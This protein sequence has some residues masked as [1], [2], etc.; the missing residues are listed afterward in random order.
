MILVSNFTTKQRINR[1]HV[2]GWERMVMLQHQSKKLLNIVQEEMSRV[3]VLQ[4]VVFVLVRT[5]VALH[6]NIMGKRRI[7][8]GSI[9]TSPK[10]QVVEIY[11]VTMTKQRIY[12]L[13]LGI[14]VFLRVDSVNPKLK[15]YRYFITW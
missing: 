2:L 9:V 3:L 1:N 5:I 4:L 10:R 8:H 14:N 15:V 7:V 11:T 13:I 6:L 12:L